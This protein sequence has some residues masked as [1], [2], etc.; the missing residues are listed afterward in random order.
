MTVT[1]SKRSVGLG[2]LLLVQAAQVPVSFAEPAGMVRIP[3]GS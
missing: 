1:V 3:A 2:C